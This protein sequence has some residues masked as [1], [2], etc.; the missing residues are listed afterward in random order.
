MA[1]TI[2]STIVLKVSGKEV[3]NSFN[4]LSKTV[5]E[6]ER[7]LKKLTPG[8]KQFM[9]KAAEL[10]EARKHFEGV[11]KEIDLLNGKLKESHGF[12]GKFFSMFKSFGFSFSDLFTLTGFG[13]GAKIVSDLL[14]ISD[15]MADVQKTTGMALEEVKQ[16][17]DEF[18]EMDTRTS[19]LDRLKIAEVGGR[20]GV[21]KEQLRD[22]VEEVDKAY[23]ALGDSFEGGL[24]GVVESLG[25]IKGLFEETKGKSYATAINE[26]GSALNELASSGTASEGNISDFTLRVGALPDALKPSIDKVLGL[27]A[28]F[29]ES[30]ID[31]QIAAS[32]YSNFM[33]VA[34]ENL[35]DF[36]YSMNMS[37]EEARALFNEKPEEFFLRFSEGMKGL[38]ADETARVF[39]SLKLNSLEVQKVVGAAA[40]KTEDFRR[41]MDLAGE[42]MKDATSLTDEFNKKNNNAAAVWEKLKNIVSNFFSQNTFINLFE[43]VII[44]VGKFAGV[45]DDA[46][47]SVSSMRQKFDALFDIIKVVGAAFL[48]YQ[49]IIIQTAIL[50]GN[51]TKAKWLDIV[52][53]KAKIVIQSTKTAVM[54]AYNSV[55]TILKIRTDQATASTTALNAVSKA[56]PWGALIGLISA[57]LTYYA[58]FSKEI[59]NTTAAK[60]RLLKATQDYMGEASRE[61]ATLD[62]LYQ[63]ATDASKGKDAQREAVEKLQRLYP[64]Y[65]GNMDKELI[66]LGQAEQKYKDLKD[67]ILASARAKAAQKI[68][69]ENVEQSLKEESKLQQEKEKNQKDLESAKS[70]K[71]DKTIEVGN[72]FFKVSQEEAIKHYENQ[73]KAI[74]KRIDKV[75][76]DLK[77]KNKYYLK[78][79]EESQE[80]A[81]P[82]ETDKA[83]QNGVVGSGNRVVAS[84]K[85]KGK[86]VTTN[87]P[88]KDDTDSAKNEDTKALKEREDFNKRMLELD[89]AL[90]DEKFKI[91]EESHE[92]ELE[93]T[94]TRQKREIEDVKQKNTDILKGM[95]ANEEKINKLQEAKSKSKSPTAQANYDKAIDELKKANSEKGVLIVKNY[96]IIKQMEE[97]HQKELAD[98]RSKHR[99]KRYEE[100]V[101]EKQKTIEAKFQEREVEIQAITTMED[102]KKALSEMKHLELTEQELKNIR[103]LEDAKKALREDA[104]REVLATEIKI[105][106]EQQKEIQ[107]LLSSESISPEARKKLLEDL[108]KANEIILRLKGNLQGKQEGDEARKSDEQKKSKDNVDILGFSASQWEEMFDNLKTT[109]GKIKG[110]IM[111]TQG[112][113]NVFRQFSKLQQNLNERELRHFTKNQDKKKTALLRQL[114]QGLITQEQYHKGVQ[115][116]EE[117]TAEKKRKIQ[118]RAAKAEKAA[119]LMSAIAGTATAVVNALK[120]APPP[121]NFALAGIVGALGAVQIATISA[122]PLP[123]FAEGGFTGKGSGK[124]DRTGFK[125]A[126]IVHEYEYVTPKWMLENP[127]VADVVDWMESIRTGKTTMPKGYAEGGLVRNGNQDARAHILE[128]KNGENYTD[129]QMMFV[130]S[131]VRDLLSSLKE[132]GVE[133]FMVE[134]AENGRRIERTVNLFKKIEQRNARKNQ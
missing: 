32:G 76:S 43:G 47:V 79:Q 102:A 25:K 12:L 78:I 54:S 113:A 45:V 114:N 129:P 69:E 101:A 133:A 1:K 44:S 21:P 103:T 22:F 121:A 41:A 117:E 37:L 26:V 124:A 10:K 123:E 40:N 23:V 108:E 46:G 134:N 100:W 34:G 5:R 59:D 75:Q 61:M 17:W 115:Q 82:Y 67:A 131:E 8:T 128:A 7:E 52:A 87:R 29:E 55:L 105:I 19:K 119:N 126:G 56:T 74:D 71:G 27:G 53:D 49:S 65:F 57:A 4:G 109:E 84:G 70:G 127:V 116:I 73:G 20:L 111:V 58:L 112:L 89:R 132:N 64:S 3:E 60:K 14:K 2:T 120:S 50:E 106:E 110:I 13:G 97:T 122:Q 51:Y 94:F 85:G 118:Q 48:G 93:M 77:E 130:L 98:I 81:S 95:D 99:V 36:A 33:K 42:S 104:A 16:L 72:T 39:D 125:P 62:K 11:K 92:K 63:A 9:D 38:E 80:K 91:M 86:G 83:N 107:K 31:A 15:A 96:D 68:I 90:E 28:A 35:K 88:A 66:M 30:G 18:D 6:L 24:E